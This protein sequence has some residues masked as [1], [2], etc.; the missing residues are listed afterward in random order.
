VYI[1][2]WYEKS[3]V[4]Y[5]MGG[6]TAGGCMGSFCMYL[7]L[8]FKP[9]V[10]TLY[11]YAGGERIAM[12]RG[13]VF[14]Y[15]LGDHLGS[16][17][18]TVDRS[19]TLTSSSSYYPWGTAHP[20]SGASP[21][22]YGFTG[23]MQEGD[24]YFYNAR[25]YDPQLGRFMQADTL[26]PLQV[27]GTQAFDRYVYTNNNPVRYT[28]PSGH[29]VC[30][31]YYGSE[32]R[33]IIKD[34]L[35]WY[36]VDGYYS[37]FG[38][39]FMGSPIVGPVSVSQEANVSD[40]VVLSSHPLHQFGSLMDILA[41]QL[42]MHIPIIENEVDKNIHWS[43]TLSVHDKTI[44]VETFWIYENIEGYKEYWS[45]D[46][47]EYS[48]GVDPRILQLI[49]RVDPDTLNYCPY[50]LDYHGLLVL[51]DPHRI[52]LAVSV[53]CGSCLNRGPMWKTFWQRIK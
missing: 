47:V 11:Y 15:L 35:P 12:M 20:N 30:D 51:G 36:E 38:S 45:V 42:G 7:P 29:R 9:P 46:I 52:D 25:W 43:L 6:Q 41:S 50:S 5:G 28:D 4:G 32:C 8:M 34:P 27:Q 13:G 37:F 31:D 3:R 44:S 49:D 14:N 10:E 39:G 16:V 21:T 19:G 24:I 2:N 23:Q 18:A 33:V 17:V 1:G 53:F 40:P 22:D 26:V 48:D